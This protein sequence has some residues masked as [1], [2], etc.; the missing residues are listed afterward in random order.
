LY[1][2]RLFE[3]R[4]EVRFTVHPLRPQ[5]YRWQNRWNLEKKKRRVIAA[6]HKATG[7]L[8]GGNSGHKTKGE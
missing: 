2:N 6:E 5:K 7:A 3:L 4:K 1:Q 8:A